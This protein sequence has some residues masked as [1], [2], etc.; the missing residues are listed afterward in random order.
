[1]TLPSLSVDLS[2][3]K[4]HTR[5]SPTEQYAVRLKLTADRHRKI[6]YLPPEAKST[7]NRPFEA[8]N[9]SSFTPFN[10]LSQDML[11]MESLIIQ[12]I[13]QRSIRYE[14]THSQRNRK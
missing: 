12:N 9:S 4:Q 14:V 6:G 11:A 3:C 8:H 1:M 7:Q 10:S 2:V 13:S 5:N